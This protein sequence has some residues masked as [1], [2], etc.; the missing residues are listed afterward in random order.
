MKVVYIVRF[1]QNPLFHS[2]PSSAT[3]LATFQSLESS[4]KPLYSIIGAS[5][6]VFTFPISCFSCV[7]MMCSFS[8]FIKTCILAIGRQLKTVALDIN[9]M[10]SKYL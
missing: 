3:S 9:N 4:E 5:Q 2:C 7:E 1:T 6:N 8:L 10:C